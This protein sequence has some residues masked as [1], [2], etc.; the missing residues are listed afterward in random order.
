MISEFLG[1]YFSYYFR[2]FLGCY[3][4]SET[5][6]EVENGEQ[7]SS[8]EGDETKKKA[9]RGRRGRKNKKK[10]DLNEGINEDFDNACSR[11][12]IIDAISKVAISSC[13]M[14]DVV[15]NTDTVVK[16]TTSDSEDP[17]ADSLEKY[18]SDEIESLRLNLEPVSLHNKNKEGEKR[19][20][21]D[22]TVEI[23]SGEELGF[24]KQKE[25]R[26]RNRKKKKSEKAKE[27]NTAVATESDKSLS[28]TKSTPDRKSKEIERKGKSPK[29][30]KSPSKTSNKATISKT[31]SPRKSLGSENMEK[32][33]F[34][35]Y[36]PDE[37][38]KAG[39][40]DGSIVKGALRINKKN[41]R[42]GY[43]KDPI[44]GLDIM[45]DGVKARNRALDG[46]EIAVKI[47]PQETWKSCDRG[48]QKCGEVVAILQKMHHRKAAGCLTPMKMQN[49][50]FALF[51]PKDYRMP[52]IRIPISQCPK[53]YKDTPEMTYLAEIFLWQDTTFAYG[54]LLK[55]IGMPG[56]IEIETDV[57]LL[58]NGLDVTPYDPSMSKYFPKS[59]YKIPV[60]EFMYRED[61]RN[62]CI[63]TI[64]PSTARDLDDAVSFKKLEDEDSFEI[65][66]HISDVAH[67]L[68]E[69][70]PLDKIVKQR[71]TTTYL[72]QS[73]FHMLPEDLCMLCSL[74]PGEDKLAFSV[75]W[76]VKPDFSIGEPRFTR[77]VIHS[78]CKMSYE[79]AQAIIDAP[80]DKVWEEHELPKILNSFS[81]ND[82]V[83]VVK[84]L[85]PI[86]L[87]LRAGRFKNGAL[88]IDQPKISFRIDAETGLPTEFNI[89][90]NMECHRLIEE[91]MLLAN[92]AVANRLFE[93][94]PDIAILR[95]H[96]SPHETLMSELSASL[97][98]HGI[99]LDV[100]SSGAIHSCLEKYL[101][102][103][104]VEKRA[105]GY[106]L[107]TML[108]KPMARAKYICSLDT[109]AE[110][111]WHYALSVPLYTHFTSPIRRYADVIVHRLLAASLK[112]TPNPDWQPDDVARI[113]SNC[114]GKKWSAKAAEAVILSVLDY[115]FDVLVIDTGT[116]HRVYTNKLDKRMVCV[117]HDI[118]K[119]TATIKWH[120][121]DKSVQKVKVFS[122]IYVELKKGN[123]MKIMCS[124]TKPP[125]INK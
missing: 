5:G 125:C 87:N 49:S 72:V 101:S 37:L 90:K 76:K 122:V 85:R 18:L 9:R 124:L 78:C 8:P 12:T 84:G 13:E 73:V 6:K 39:L 96:P 113:A 36:M 86:A 106:G 58:D 22:F 14:L 119:K 94:F 88:R 21:D 17:N 75:F 7:A 121:P 93:H 120:Q 79:H 53:N 57:I 92:I 50:V 45:L 25:K 97:H 43:I 16:L 102:M 82:V 89:Y 114:N 115:S 105:I 59:P 80:D 66:V 117:D 63:F 20:G 19:E 100:S 108:A 123:D 28:T 24:E 83:S 56:S 44:G 71:A 60:S 112:Y 23:V 33:K 15:L 2:S 31:K 110:D 61:L 26:V 30:A 81:V 69:D 65:G 1:T 38:V 48:V 62:Q 107:S 11:D 54:N 41:F 103:E 68:S 27:A 47:L 32:E 104:D 34:S 99:D 91:L 4:C 77:S 29:L 40:E 95:S 116:S 111:Q 46:D 74:T 51:V 55:I 64:D 109:K 52:R 42:E 67:F 98:D 118:S 3:S 35:D 70:T 10:P